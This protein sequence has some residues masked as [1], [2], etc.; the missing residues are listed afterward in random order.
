MYCEWIDDR[1]KI[2]MNNLYL[3]KLHDRSIEVKFDNNNNKIINC[4]C[5]RNVTNKNFIKRLQFKKSEKFDYEKSLTDIDL[6]YKGKIKNIDESKL[7]AKKK[8][9][10]LKTMRTKCQKKKNGV[11]K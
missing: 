3:P 10:M 7:S 9:I 8:S 4:N 2:L 1:S 5:F 11:E 6:E